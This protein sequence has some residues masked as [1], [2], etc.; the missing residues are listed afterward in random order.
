MVLYVTSAFA[1][2]I[3][4]EARLVFICCSDKYVIKIRPKGPV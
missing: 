1:Q 2:M 3:N 4:F